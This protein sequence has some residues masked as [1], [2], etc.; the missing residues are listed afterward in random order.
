MGRR[1]CH[2]LDGVTPFSS[3]ASDY[4]R[5]R[6]SYP[7]AAIAAILQGLGPR[8]VVVD[9][10]AGTGVATRLLA[11][12]ATH[13]TG[14][15]PNREMIRAAPPEPSVA[16]V[17]AHAE[18]L[19][20]RRASVDLVTAFGAF[21]WFQPGEFL[22]GARRALRSRGRL[23]VVWN[24]WDLSD[25]FTTAFVALMRSAAADHPPEDRALEAAPLYRSSRFCDVQAWEFPLAHR[26]DRETLAARLRSVSYVPNEGE[27]WDTLAAAAEALFETHV[28]ASG[29]VTQRYVTRAFVARPR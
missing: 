10:G 15:E 18:A 6:P 14:V 7:D 13:A 23:A 3:R 8:P 17:Q 22:A 26:L 27:A 28:D 5:G 19:P 9:V 1:S 12:A 29:T 24:D 2:D 25:A 16:F 20:L 11:H 21:H 4:A